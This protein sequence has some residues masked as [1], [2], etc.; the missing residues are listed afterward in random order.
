ML[1]PEWIPFLNQHHG[2]W[3]EAA[4]SASKSRNRG[5]AQRVSGEDADAIGPVEIVVETANSR[6]NSHLGHDSGESGVESMEL[7][8][9]SE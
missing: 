6:V 7:G 5:P 2:Y 1:G 9:S 3:R 4:A 8:V